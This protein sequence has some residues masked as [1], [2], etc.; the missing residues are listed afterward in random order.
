M[1]PH[2][3]DFTFYLRLPKLVALVNLTVRSPELSRGFV[4]LGSERAGAKLI[5]DFF[6]LSHQPLLA[7]LLLTLCMFVIERIKF[8]DAARRT[9]FPNFLLFLNIAAFI[10]LRLYSLSRNRDMAAIVKVTINASD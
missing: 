6:E 7:L 3:K 8:L 9:N 2:F 10:R 4:Y 1:L 5:C